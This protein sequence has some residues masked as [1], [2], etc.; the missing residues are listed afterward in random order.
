MVK[1][2]DVLS[3]IATATSLLASKK[4]ELSAF[5]E[6][7]S[8][9]SNVDTVIEYVL[10]SHSHIKESYS[11]AG[12]PYLNETTREEEHLKEV[13]NE[14]DIKRDEI[15]LKLDIKINQLN[16]DIS[17]LNTQLKWL[18]LDLRYAED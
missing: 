1:K 17:D 9:L 10:V 6:A 11:L 18:Q 12:T 7:K 13:T 15:M 16:M 3:K 14:L 2:A 8:A 5:L 4:S